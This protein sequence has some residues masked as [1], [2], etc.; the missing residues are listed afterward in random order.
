MYVDVAFVRSKFLSVNVV[1]ENKRQIM[2]LV[3]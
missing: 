3:I 2:E 1:D